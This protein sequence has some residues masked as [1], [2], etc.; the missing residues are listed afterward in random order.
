MSLC[1]P[2]RLVLFLAWGFC[3]ILICLGLYHLIHFIIISWMPVRFLIRH[4]KSMGQD[5]RG[6]VKELEGVR[7]EEI[8]IHCKKMSL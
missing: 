1:L 8:R 5:G 6:G 3:P 4:K 7:G 2:V